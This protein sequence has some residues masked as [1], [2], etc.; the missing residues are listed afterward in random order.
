MEAVVK[1][2]ILTIFDDLP[3]GS[4]LAA[5]WI[6]DHPEDVALLSMREQ[7]KR[8][9]VPAATMTRLAQRLGYSGYEALRAVSSSE[10]RQ[11]SDFSGR[12]AGLLARR[13]L[14]GDE[15]LTSDVLAGL[16]GHLRALSSRDTLA[17]I[18]HAADVIVSRER[19]FCIGARSSY[20]SAHLS[21]YLLSLIG[22]K[23]VLVDGAG[24]TGLDR[25]H[26]VGAS[27]ALL[28]VTIA[29]YT[30]VT[31][32]AA[33][34]AQEKGAAVIAITDSAASPIARLAPASV[35]VPTSTPSFLQTVAPGLIVVECI[36]ALVA[37]RRGQAAV[38]A[39]AASEELLA[40]FG[41][42]HDDT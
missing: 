13:E 36:A 35:V 10:L 16:A 28:A 20:A 17:S 41:A 9:G 11:R 21:A 30:R 27:D 15:A 33:V 22:E 40:R 5:R 18:V 39:M 4:R 29:P 6:M 42:Y 8:A 37:A 3:S 32:E 2:Q 1:R 31:V 19:L 7:A 38:D 25:L 26:G 34:Y 24:A 12:T 23:A 14:D